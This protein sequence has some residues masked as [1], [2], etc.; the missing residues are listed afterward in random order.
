MPKLTSAGEGT[1]DVEEGKRLVLAIEDLGID[2][3][4]RCGGNARCTTCRVHFIEGEPDKQTQ[5]GKERIQRAIDN[6]DTEM[7]TARLSCQITVD[8]DMHVKVLKRVRDNTWDSPGG[9]PAE[10]ITPDPVW[11]TKE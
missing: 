2:I 5:A 9:Q 1:F 7:K 11:I 4:H 6:D 10:S 3:G 8:E